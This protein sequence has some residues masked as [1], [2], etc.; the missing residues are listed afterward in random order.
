MSVPRTLVHCI[1]HWAETTPT[2]PALHGKR[3]GVWFALT[4]SDYWENVRTL[5]K[6]FISMGVER[7]DCVTFCGRND[8]AWLELQFA[9]QA[10][11]GIPAPIY[12]TNTVEQ[13]A[14]I[15]GNCRA[16]I[17]V[18]DGDEQLDKLLRA[19]REGLFPALAHIVM[20]AD[21]TRRD[22]ARIKSFDECLALGRAESDATLDA[23]LDALT[24]DETCQLI[25]TSGTTGQP[26]G[27]MLTHAG[28]LFVGEAVVKR[29]EA[30][31]SPERYIALSYL[32]LCHQAEQL[33]SSVFSLVTG[34]QVYFCPDIAQIREYLLEVRPT[35]FLGVP[36]VWE[37]F[38]AALAAR[39]AQATGV[40]GVLA[41]L[42]R[43]AELEAFERQ[44]ELGDPTYSN[45]RRKLARKLVIDNVKA[46]LGLDR[47]EVAATGSA[48]ISASTQQFFA[49]LGICIYEG[50]GMSENSGL[51]T[52]T[53]YRKPRFGTVGTPLEGMELRI[54]DD[55]EILLR[56]PNNTKGYLHMPE[57]S[58]ELYEADGWLRTG[59]LGGLDD[60][61]N[62]IITGRIKELIITAGGKNV[63]PVEMENYIKTIVGVGNAVVVGD[64]QP[65][66]CALVTLD[67][68]ALDR[69][70]DAA[71]VPRAP[72]AE[73]ATNKKVR[74][75]LE[76]KIETECNRKV[77]RYQTIKKI[78]ILPHEFSVEAD[79]LTATMKIKRAVI[80]QKY[81]DVIARFYQAGGT[82]AEDSH[83]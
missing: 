32:P 78:E 81:A 55:G 82:T 30:V 69:L 9:L 79:E 13:T 51:A 27:V 6:A 57:A 26:K 68:E 34:G 49:S 43:A 20:Y 37:K 62:L 17:A 2:R 3:G 56:G 47:I 50:Y 45:V 44:V 29:F 23:R 64:R 76:Q 10:V 38:E 42:A 14:Y 5:G 33:F 58:K 24:P 72:M 12:A 70:A 19:E 54:S 63:A 60:E 41:K 15:I 46:A 66:L 83:A 35:V 8:P 21:V 73:L 25:Y 80:A 1:R 39:L 16:R 65:F 67:P 7:G 11:Q 53:D 59:D 48:P 22:D 77:A 28:Q 4:W 71:G 61:G 18:V 31:A 75:Y 74:A 36:R 52:I 40:K